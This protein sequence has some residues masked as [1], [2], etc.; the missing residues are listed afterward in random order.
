MTSRYL[1]E[2]NKLCFELY[3]AVLL[4]SKYY[5]INSE[6]F[7]WDVIDEDVYEYSLLCYIWF[8]CKH[9]NFPISVLPNARLECTELVIVLYFYSLAFHIT[10]YRKLEAKQHTPVGKT[11]NI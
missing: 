8:V 7:Q 1:K 10:P 6:K 11:D 9:L 5:H 4:G 3:I 2:H